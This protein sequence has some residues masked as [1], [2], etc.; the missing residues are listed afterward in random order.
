[1]LG[2]DVCRHD[3]RGCQLAYDVPMERIGPY[4]ILGRI[5]RGGSADVF[6]ARNGGTRCVIKRLHEHLAADETFVRMFLDEARVMSL[7]P[8]PS[9]VHV[10]DLG[11]DG[12]TCYSV[13]EVIDGPNL[14]AVDKLLRD[15]KR[16][17][18]T[19]VITAIAAAIADAL[20]FVHGA[21]DPA[22]GE[23]LGLVHR[24]V[25]APNILVS[26]NGDVKLT[27]FGVVRSQRARALGVLSSEPTNA[28]TIKGR[29]ATMSPEQARGHA[30]D[31]RSDLFSLGVVLWESLAGTTLWNGDLV[32]ALTRAPAPPV[33]RTDIASALAALIAALLEKS[34]DARPR[35][36]SEVAAALRA[37]RDT[38]VL[39]ADG[40]IAELV[41]SLGVPSL[42]ADL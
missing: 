21:I 32:D 11:E 18:P 16:T 1:M 9:I 2:K 41:R 14:A 17:M 39:H 5:G 6:L 7:L 23:P 15:A 3:E 36:A 19:A 24:D 38:R 27:D 25:A 35:A 4:A 31:A 34:P 30:V 33:P 42:A 40:E 20:A 12:P 8:H 10:F 22:S 13:M 29:R 26:R 28:G 37:V